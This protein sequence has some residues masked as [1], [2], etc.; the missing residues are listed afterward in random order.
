MLTTFI[1][2]HDCD[3]RFG[4]I[5]MID[6]SHTWRECGGSDSTTRHFARR[7]PAELDRL[8]AE[9]AAFNHAQVRPVPMAIPRG[10]MSFHH[11]R[12]YHGSGANNAGTPRRAISLHLQDGDNRYTAFRLSDG[13]TVRYNHDHLVRRTEDGAP[14]Y[15]DPQFCPVLWRSRD[16]VP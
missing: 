4:T 9:N 6:G 14:D 12:I 5:T 3:E 2:F 8:L 10:H 7:D 1:P 15:T 13:T 11:C 16:S